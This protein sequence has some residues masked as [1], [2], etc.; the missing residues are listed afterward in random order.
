M[1]VYVHT[2]AVRRNPKLQSN[3]ICL[4]RLRAVKVVLCDV[5][6]AVGLVQYVSLTPRGLVG[7]EDTSPTDTSLTY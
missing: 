3:P 1:L 2:G 4:I 7:A 6:V 5:D